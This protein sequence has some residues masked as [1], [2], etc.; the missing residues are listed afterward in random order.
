MRWLLISL[1]LLIS[2]SVYAI[3]DVVNEL[4]SR[5]NIPKSELLE[6]LSNCEKNQLSMN[7]CA[8]RDFITVNQQA[9]RIMESKRADRTDTCYTQIQRKQMK[10]EKHRD[11]RCGKEAGLPNNGGTM[12]GMVYNSCRALLTEQRLKVLVQ[13]ENCASS[14]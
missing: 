1:F 10:W 9:R 6:L 14:H 2:L 12:S 7:M 3:D 8:W 4:S 13:D 11:Q 5:S